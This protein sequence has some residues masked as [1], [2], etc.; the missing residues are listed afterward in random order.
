MS[1]NGLESIQILN[2]AIIKLKEKGLN[3]SYEERLKRVCDS[4]ALDAINRSISLLSEG[5]KISRDQA[6]VIIIDTIRELDAVW[7]DYIMM[8]GIDK[9]KSLLKAQDS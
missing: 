1:S 8:E 6:A 4:P 7:N 3:S 2:T 5:Q 9:L